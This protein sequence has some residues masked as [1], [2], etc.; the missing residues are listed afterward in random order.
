MFRRK[1]LQY[2]ILVLAVLANLAIAEAASAGLKN[3]RFVDQE[4]GEFYDCCEWCFLLCDC[5]LVP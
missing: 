3:A 5:D 4:T 2:L 1:V